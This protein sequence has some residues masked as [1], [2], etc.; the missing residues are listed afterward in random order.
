MRSVQCLLVLLSGVFVLSAQF[1]PES[2]HVFLYFPQLVDGGSSVQA[3]ETTVVFN[4]TNPGSVVCFLDLLGNNG[5]ALRLDFGAG[6]ASRHTVTIPGQGRRT[7]RSRVAS[8]SIVTGWAIGSCGLP[9][10]ATVSFRLLQNGLGQVDI[11]APPVTPSSLFRAPANA[12]LGIAIAN[13]YTDTSLP[14]RVTA[15]D[16]E[17]R[18]VGA[19]TLTVC[20]KCHLSVNLGTILPGLPGG[21]EGSVKLVSDSPANVFVA[22]MLSSERGLLASLPS[23]GVGWPISHFDRIW[24]VYLKLLFGLRSVFPDLDLSNVR[25]QIPNDRIVNARA[26]ADGTVQIN[27]ALSQLISDSP[28]ELAFAIGHELGHIVQFKMNARPDELD[29]DRAGAVLCL[30]SGFDPYGGAGL[31]GK[32]MMASGRTGIIDQLF[33]NLQDPHSSFTNRIGA[34]L[35]TLTAACSNPAAQAA[36]STYKELIH[37]NLPGILPLNVPVP[38]APPARNET[39]PQQH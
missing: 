38:G 35:S 29:A 12:A 37:P 26:F 39:I 33:D 21:F 11:A 7:L 18:S 4:N 17:G 14:I 13:V 36:C 16:T 32:L 22:W 5:E 10:Q 28:S 1:E 6:L 23:G 31:F 9:V 3:W 30:V 8:P 27:L 20:G 19:T 25:L 24:L 2:A 15:Y 34:L